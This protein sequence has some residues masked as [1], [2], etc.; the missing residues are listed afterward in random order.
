MKENKL[1]LIHEPDRVRL[2]SS[3][4]WERK[5][6]R[7][8]VYTNAREHVQVLA[9]EIG[10]RNPGNP[11]NLQRA[12]SYIFDWLSHVGLEPRLESYEAGGVEVSNIIAE[13]PGFDMPQEIVLIGAHYDTVEGSPGADDNASSIAGLLEIARILA[14]FRFRKTLRLVAF[15]LEEPPFFGTEL[16]GSAFHAKGCRARNENIEL[17]ICLEMI[18]YAGRKYRQTIPFEDIRKHTPQF[19]NYLGVFSLPSCEWYTE[20]WKTIYN[21]HSARKTFNV[22]GPA[23]IPGMD[24]SDHRSF[25]ERAYPAVM[26][27]DSGHYRNN[28]YHTDKDTADTLNYN[29]LADNIC[30]ISRALRELLSIDPLQGPQITR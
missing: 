6:E 24:L 14:R 16:M 11:Y 22:T 18:G 30:G 7:N 28:N 29:F 15:T 27:S 17:M 19:G 25:I 1:M 2:F 8:R 26:L 12:G 13:I 3:A 21:R 9:S 20:L 5:R 4:Y 23:S 10:E